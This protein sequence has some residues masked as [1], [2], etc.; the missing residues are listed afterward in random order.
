MVDSIF[1]ILGAMM[2]VLRYMTAISVMVYICY[3]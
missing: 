2:V 1:N 3:I